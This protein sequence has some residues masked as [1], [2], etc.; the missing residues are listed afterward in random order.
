MQAVIG[1]AQLA[2]LPAFIEARR[3]N[4]AALTAGLNHHAGSFILPVPPPKAEPSWFGYVITVRPEAP[5][6][7]EELVAA[8]DEAKIETRNLFCGNLLRQPAYAG[9]RHRVAGVL[10][11]TDTIMNRTFFV[12]VHPGISGAMQR[13][14][15]ATFDEFIA[16]RV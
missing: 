8:L 16:G 10:D 11:N 14:V 6:T 3:Q 13:H 7:R 4:H 12:G 1:V 9:I 5:F 2:K 15:L